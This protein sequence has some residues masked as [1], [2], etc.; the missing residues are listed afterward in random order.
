LLRSRLV[1]PIVLAAAFAACSTP[2]SS[3][4]PTLPTLTNPGVTLPAASTLASAGTAALCGGWQEISTSW[5]PANADA[6]LRVGQTFHQW[7][8]DPALASISGDLTTVFNWL[9]AASIS[10]A[11]ATPPADAQAAFDKVK[12]FAEANC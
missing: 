6:A 9:A 12:S 10:T 2:G 3:S 11:A 4:A 7:A 8:G 5:P 1:L